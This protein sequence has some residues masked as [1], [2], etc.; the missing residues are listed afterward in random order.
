MRLFIRT[1]KDVTNKVCFLCV[2]YIECPPFCSFAESFIGD[3]LSGVFLHAV[4]FESQSRFMHK[5]IHNLPINPG[6]AN[7]IRELLFLAPQNGSREIRL[8]NR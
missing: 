7:T 4:E 8:P 3:N 5:I 1:V 6:V 2:G